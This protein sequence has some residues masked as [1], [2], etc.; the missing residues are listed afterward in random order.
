MEKRYLI[1]RCDSFCYSF[2]IYDEI[3]SPDV[4]CQQVVCAV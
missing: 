1:Y 2:L 4:R 3:L